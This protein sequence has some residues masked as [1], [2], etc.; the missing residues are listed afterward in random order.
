MLS[1]MDSIKKFEK[2]VKICLK[3][4]HEDAYIVLAEPTTY[5][6]FELQEV[7]KENNTMKIVEWYKKNLPSLIR[8]HCFDEKNNEI[9]IANLFDNFHLFEKIIEEYGTFLSKSETSKKK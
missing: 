8:E 5:Q 3:E 6:M 4:L 7:A 1:L 9:V 2:T